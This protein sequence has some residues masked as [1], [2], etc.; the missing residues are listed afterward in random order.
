[1]SLRSAL[2]ISRGP[3]TAFVVVG[4]Y[5][6]AFAAFVPVI[7]AR[8]GADDAT[9]GT[10]LLGTAVGLLSAMWLAPRFDQ[11][12]RDRGLQL[13]ALALALAFL[14][15][16]LM[17][18]PAGFAFSMVAVGMASGLTDVLMNAR[19]SELEASNKRSLMNAN[20]A[21]F[22][23]GYAVAAIATGAA[24]EAGLAPAAMFALT[25]VAVLLL[26]PQLRLSAAS[27]GPGRDAAGTFPRNLVLLC[28]LI[29]LIA[30]MSEAAV[31]SWSALHVERTLGGRAAEGALGP[32]VL[33]LT[34]AI[35]RF[36]GQLAADRLSELAVITAATIV[37]AMGA[38]IAAAAPTPALAYLGFGTLGLGVSVIGPLGLALT[39]RLV[40]GRMRTRAISRVA[41]IGFMGFFAAP[42]LM[43]G[44]SQL[45]GLR[46]A[47]AA[48]ALLLAMLFPVIALLAHRRKA[49]SL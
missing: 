33:G 7:K 10:L 41:V 22:S 4:L 20:H 26:L 14:L 48:I 17:T 28:G 40:P 24:R 11:S 2:R 16:G 32:A 3:A 8:I 15:P 1:M 39:G 19:V 37:S 5:W 34:M 49:S 44:V 21:M 23:L 27:P 38:V 9:F 31:E 12:L 29:V 43:G 18:T 42:V 45:Y 13:A 30:F 25:G 47:F 46:W 35:G 6:G 36:S